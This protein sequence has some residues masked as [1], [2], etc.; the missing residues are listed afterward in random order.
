MAVGDRI[1]GGDVAHLR[2]DNY[3]RLPAAIGVFYDDEIRG[4]RDRLGLWLCTVGTDLVS[5][6]NL[7]LGL[8]RKCSVRVCKVRSH[9]IGNKLYP[10][11]FSHGA[12]L[13]GYLPSIE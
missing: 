9:G 3:T 4:E 10:L 5:V 7:E 1:V 8:D 6:G 13:L 12:S 2:L 11:R